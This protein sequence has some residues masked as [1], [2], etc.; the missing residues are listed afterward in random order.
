MKSKLKIYLNPLGQIEEKV[1]LIINGGCKSGR[2]L[3]K[4]L[5]KQGVNIAFIYLHEDEYIQ[6]TI[7][8]LE[9]ENIQFLAIKGNINS[10]Y[11]YSKAIKEIVKK[12]GGIDI[13]IN[14]SQLT[15]ET[16]DTKNKK[17]M[18]T[19]YKEL[20]H[21]VHTC[22]PYMDKG[23]YIINTNSIRKDYLSK[24]KN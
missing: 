13:L 10:K 22:L 2:N 15:N 4:S 18:T 6:D 11:F 12:F 24:K 7:E 5:A 14:N 3:C 21:L 8:K 16:A 17:N 23:S 9:D 20:H 19:P 1:A